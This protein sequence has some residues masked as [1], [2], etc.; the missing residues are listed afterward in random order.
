MS[1]TVLPPVDF[2]KIVA[3][4]TRQ[5]QATGDFPDIYKLSRSYRCTPEEIQRAIDMVGSANQPIMPEVPEL[6][7]KIPVGRKKNEPV[8][9]EDP[10][11]SKDPIPPSPV[12]RVHNLELPVLKIFL[13][14]LA[15]ACGARSFGYVY[16]WV[17]KYDGAFL[18]ATLASIVSV[19]MLILP[20]TA[21]HIL[22]S[23]RHG[24]LK[25]LPVWAMSVFLA[26]F[27]GMTTASGIYDART[28]GAESASAQ[29]K[30]AL[31]AEVDKKAI[32]DKLTLANELVTSR[33]ME[34]TLALE[35]LKAAIAGEDER[36][37]TLAQNRVDKLRKE[38]ETA[39]KDLSG[40]QDQ[41]AVVS[42]KT[43]ERP[44]RTD[45]MAWIGGI[46]GTEAETVELWTAMGPAIIVDVIGPVAACL[47]MF[48]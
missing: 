2:D 8:K 21:W 35:G 28:I 22:R 20:Q 16:E 12:H 47:A 15:L 6:K 48:L 3:A 14:I 33:T 17:Y 19:A 46:I 36:K 29:H 31:L 5:K 41:L 7:N 24:W 30:D 34:L 39:R 25:S 1:D 40:L 43:M 13:G 44:T 9:P 26:L 18:A 45:A 38:L 10:P 27:C 42:K 23:S 37:T 11:V 32:E 4:V